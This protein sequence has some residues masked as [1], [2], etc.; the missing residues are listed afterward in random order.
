[1]KTISAITFVTLFNTFTMQALAAAVTPPAAVAPVI[2]VAS[3]TPIVA[4]Q[5]F[6]S[7]KPTLL[8]GKFC[9]CGCEKIKPAFDI[10]T[11]SCPESKFYQFNIGIAANCRGVENTEDCEFFK[12]SDG[13]LTDAYKKCRDDLDSIKDDCENCKDCSIPGAAKD[14]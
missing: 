7:G 4:E 14:D 1:M 8:V 12:K 2:P 6:C 5:C 9:D 3:F 13:K 10:Y 11:K